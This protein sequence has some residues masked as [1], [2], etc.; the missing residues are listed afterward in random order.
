MTTMGP[1]QFRTQPN[2]A[3]LLGRGC[4]W[5]SRCWHGVEYGEAQRQKLSPVAVGEE[6]EVADADEAFGKQVQQEVA[7]E[8]IQR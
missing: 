2:R 5:F 3:Q 1:P 4:F 7:Q 8:F 6:P